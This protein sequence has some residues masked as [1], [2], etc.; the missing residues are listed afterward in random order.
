MG[1]IVLVYV[2]FYGLLEN[3]GGGKWDRDSPAAIRIEKIL[4]FLG[5][6]TSFS[7]FGWVSIVTMVGSCG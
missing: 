3:F 6:W 4:L 2:G 1:I 7:R 5:T